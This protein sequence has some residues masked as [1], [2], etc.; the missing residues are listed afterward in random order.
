MYQLNKNHVLTESEYRELSAILR[1]DNSRD[2]CLI[3][4]A[5][6]TGGRSQEIL[7]L[8]NGDL[9]LE[10]GSVYLRGIK[11][12]HNR[13]IPISNDLRLKLIKLVG[14]SPDPKSKVFAIK[15]SRFRQIWMRKR[16]CFKKLHALRHTFAIRLFNAS[17]D[18]MLV[19]KA[20]GHKNINNTMVYL[21]FD[22]NDNQIRKYLELSR[23]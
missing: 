8:T 14:K 11:G 5:I 6:E 7:N 1:G 23:G 17:K 3:G 10:T 22:Y 20:L 21:D 19:Q 2:A 16:P 9:D 15:T 18:I 12:S 13:S 4:L